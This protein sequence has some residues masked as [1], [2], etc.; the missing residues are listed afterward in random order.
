MPAARDEVRVLETR[1]AVCQWLAVELANA[2]ACA[3]QH[4]ELWH[5]WDGG[6]F[7]IL[8]CRPE[9][10]TDTFWLFSVLVGTGGGG[11]GSHGDGGG[12]L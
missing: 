10:A 5:F 1:F 8:T 9:S 11:G 3:G 2:A 6:I 7:H 4:G 12:G